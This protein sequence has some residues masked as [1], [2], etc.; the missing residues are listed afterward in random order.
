MRFDDLMLPAKAT[1]RRIGVR[2]WSA[3][4]RTD[5]FTVT[6]SDYWTGI[7]ALAAFW[8]HE[9]VEAPVADGTDEIALA[10][11]TDA[12]SRSYR[13]RVLTTRPGRGAVRSRHGLA[14]LPDADPKAGRFVLPAPAGPPAAQ[15]DASLAA[16]GKRYGPRVARLAQLGLEYDPP[17]AGGR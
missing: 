17:K 7:S 15:I 4:H 10:L 13:T 16:M 2:D 3:T 9:T 12:W 14:I 11:R 5:D 6:A 8:A 1:A